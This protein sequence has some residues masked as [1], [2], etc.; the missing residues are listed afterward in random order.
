MT[1]LVGSVVRYSDQ[2]YT[3][4]THFEERQPPVSLISLPVG[5]SSD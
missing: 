1:E 3:G 4:Y 2:R 5:L